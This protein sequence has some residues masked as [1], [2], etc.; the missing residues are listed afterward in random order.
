[1]GGGQEIAISQV[2]REQATREK[3]ISSPM[4]ITSLVQKAEGDKA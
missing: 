1:M 2:V 4:R 3:V